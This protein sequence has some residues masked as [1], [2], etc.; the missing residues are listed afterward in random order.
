[1]LQPRRSRESAQVGIRPCF[2]AD[3]AFRA[4]A[5]EDT[6]FRRKRH[7][8]KRNAGEQ[9][10]GAAAGQIRA[11]DGSS[12]QGVACKDDTGSGEVEGHAIGGV[13]GGVGRRDFKTTERKGAGGVNQCVDLIGF[14]ADWHAPVAGGRLEGELGRI[15]GEGVDFGTAGADFGDVFDVVVVL[16]GE[17]QVI[18]S[19]TKLAK[20]IGDPFGRVD[21]QI[22]VR[23]FD[24][25]AVGLHHA[26]SIEGNLHKARRRCWPGQRLAKPK[27]P[28]TPNLRRLL[29]SSVGVAHRLGS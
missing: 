13:T 28:P 21:E 24:E 12:K 3:R 8:M 2:T 19:H 18:D 17:Q 7:E 6:G 14:H 22:A 26:T 11:T 1:M 4:V 5:G 25:V 27:M 23:A 29:G 10:F 15:V 20:P 9:F 16:M